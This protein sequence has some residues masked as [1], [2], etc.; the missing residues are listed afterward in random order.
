MT[1]GKNK[2]DVSLKT[3]GR[4]F[5]PYQVEAILD[6]NRLVLWEK[7]IRIGATFCMAFRAVRRRVLGK[8]DCL[9]TSVSLP[10]AKEFIE[11]CKKYNEIFKFAASDIQAVAWGEKLNE[12]G[13]CITYPNGCRIFAFSSNPKAIRSFGG[14]VM[15]DEIAFHEDPRSMI[16]A[17]GGRALWGYPVTIWSSHNGYDNEWNRILTEERAKGSKSKWTIKSTTLIDA[18]RDGLLG[19]INEVSG[20]SKTDADFLEETKEM[21]GGE[22]AFEEECL[23]K[24]RKGGASAIKWSYLE[25]AKRDYNITRFK[26]EGD[27]KDSIESAADAMIEMLKDFT[28]SALGY[29][30]AR[31]GHLAAVWINSKAEKNTLRGLVTFKNTKFGNQRELIARIMRKSLTTVGAGDKTGLGMQ[32][33]E[34]LE[35]EFGEARFFGLNFGARKPDLGTRLTKIYESGEQEIPAAVDQGDIAHDL[36]GIRLEA[37]PSG[38]PHFYESSN[39]LNK[40]SHCDLAWANALALAAAENETGCGVW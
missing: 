36:A 27:D 11:Q 35:E 1:N 30:V 4:Y 9:V 33:C 23:C 18:M 7:S 34:E 29:D 22:E 16:K 26:I 20:Q 14:E 12:Q 10:A 6:E 15:I 5:L 38:R 13:Y 32:V 3:I 37:L 28:A 8:G 21:V 19:K 24:P 25:A 31:T 39:P 17:A 2:T 40:D